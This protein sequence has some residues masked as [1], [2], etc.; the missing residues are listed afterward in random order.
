MII[1]QQS[2]TQKLNQ[3]K[4]K[5]SYALS[6]ITELFLQERHMNKL[7]IAAIAIFGLV[8]VAA[9]GMGHHGMHGG[10]MHRAGMHPGM[11]FNDKMHQQLN[12]TGE[13]ET[14]WQALKAQ[15]ET[16]HKQ[17]RD[18]HMQTRAAVKAEM[19][20]AQPDLIA[21][22][23]MMEAAQDKDIATKKAFHKDALKFY[24]NLSPDRQAIVVGEIK[25]MMGKMQ[26][27]REK[28][29]GM[30]GK[31]DKMPNHQ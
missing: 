18:G 4:R 12:L 19:D 21:I 24:S 17:M 27:M 6:V 31:H 5:Q 1:V 30:N 10:G 13:Q 23:N 25:G 28:M 26:G 8:G 2:T 22:S 3:V 11:I 20:K 16:I 29:H 15:H 9:A 7:A 14:Q